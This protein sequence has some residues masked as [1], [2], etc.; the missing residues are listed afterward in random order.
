MWYV[1]LDGNIIPTPYRTM[2]EAMNACDD[3]KRRLGAC[4]CDVVYLT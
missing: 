2:R 1:K 3:Y 4:V